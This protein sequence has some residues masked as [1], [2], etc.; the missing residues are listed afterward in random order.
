MSAN[1]SATGTKKSAVG[2]MTAVSKVKAEEPL[3]GWRILTTRA[4]KQSGGLA[5]P[6]REMGAEVIE[7]PTI[8]IKPP[9]SYKALDAALKNIAKYDWLILT[10]VNGVEALFARLKKLRVAP[11]KLAHLQV[12]AIGPATQREIENNGL[13]VAV[14]PDRYV[15]EAVVEALK[16]KTQAKRVLLVRAKVARDVLPTELRKS[17]AK[18]DVAEAYETHVP[19]GAKA[20]LNRLFSNDTSRPDIVTFTSSS[21]ATNFLALLEKD[22]W[23]GLREI[24]LAS[25]GPVT[26]DT[27]RHAGFKPNIEALEY[28]MEGLTLA[29]CKHVLT[30]HPSE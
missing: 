19:K 3:S 29:I 22:H 30:T 21:T 17:G 10:S 9:T 14:T 7:I 4:S 16:G 23:H 15:A 1:K 5:A 13:E 11:E 18:V 8:E 24:W 26:S 25:I 2:P 28:T 27:L 20:K 6:L 12:A